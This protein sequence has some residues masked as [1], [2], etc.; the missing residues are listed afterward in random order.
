MKFLQESKLFIFS[1]HFLK[2]VGLVLLFYITIVLLTMMYLHFSTNHGEKIS[3]PNF[4]GM[5]SEKA[6]A[7]I[8]ELDLVYEIRD[9]VYRPELP[10]G[11]VIFQSP[12]PTS[13]SLLYAKSG[14]TISL[15]VSKNSDY[16][17]MPSL[18]DKQINKFD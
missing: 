15:R 6:I 18:I 12:S 3:I 11:T 5:S 10:Q 7:L 4:T 16:T 13:T 14:R 8:E 9:S 17:E 2:H 1:K